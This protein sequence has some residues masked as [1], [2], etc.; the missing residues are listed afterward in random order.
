M[1]HITNGDSAGDSLRRA[2]PSG[3]VLAWRD[4]LHAGPVPAG[5]A[6][7]ALSEVRAKAIADVGWSEYAT[8]LADFR[9]RDATLAAF[10]DHDE[11]VLWFEHDLYDQLQ[12]LQ[13]LDWLATHAPG[14]TRL[15]LLCIGDYPVAP[16]FVGLGQLTPA[17]LAGLFPQRHAITGDE[18]ALARAGWAAFRA[19]DPTAFVAL[20]ASDTA[21]LPFL[22]GALTRLLEE[23]PGVGDGLARTERQILELVAAG[24]DAPALLFAQAQEREAAPYMGDLT[25]WTHLRTLSDGPAPLLALPDGARF[26]LPAAQGGTAAFNA[27]RLTLTDAG[28]SVLA[29]HADWATLAGLDRWLGG[30]HLLGHTP[31]WRWDRH[32]QRLAPGGQ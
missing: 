1:L 25:F 8:V 20:L 30:V 28:R 15:S 3:A 21:A 5:L 13:I 23:Y 11:V 22:A 14:A 12:L 17:Q 2:G 32:E 26:A 4:V 19:P 24:V 9:A 31:A 18:L 6:L 29:G 7:D 16:R 27:Q 10:T